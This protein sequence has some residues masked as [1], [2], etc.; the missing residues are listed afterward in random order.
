M[1]RLYSRF[2]NSLLEPIWNRN[3]IAGVQITLAE[4]FGIQGRRRFSETAGWLR[5]VIENHLFQ[6]VAIARP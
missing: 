1:N 2:A 6:V 3:Y 5:D 4:Q